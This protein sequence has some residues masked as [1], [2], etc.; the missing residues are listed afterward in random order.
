MSLALHEPELLV[1]DQEE[2]EFSTRSVAEYLSLWGGDPCY[3]KYPRQHGDG[4]VFYNYSSDGDDL[5]Y[6]ETMLIPAVKR[7]MIT[8]NVPVER[9]M[10]AEDTKCFQSILEYAEAKVTALKAGL[11]LSPMV[12]ENET[13]RTTEGIVIQYK[14]IQ[15]CIAEPYEMTLTGEDTAAIQDAISLGIDGR[16]QACYVPSRGD[17]YEWGPHDSCNTTL[18]IAVSGESM[19]ILLRRLFEGKRECGY[20]LAK[21]IMDDLGLDDYGNSKYL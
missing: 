21:D 5:K 19:P 1:E 4:Y 18:Q 10:S 2:G 14:Q 8:E 9:Q 13:F 15:D 12:R 6:L 17:K 11:N 7:Q 3:D 20:Q 16:L